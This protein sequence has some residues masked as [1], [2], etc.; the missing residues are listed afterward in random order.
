MPYRN[1]EPVNFLL[2]DD[3]EEN[4]ISLEAL[5]RH[6][7]VN[8]LKA[9]SGPEALELLLKHDIGLA[10]LDVQMPE[11]DGFELAELMRG[12][13]RTSK[14]PIIFLTAGSV[15]R[16][17]RFRGYE[18]G[19]VDFIQKPI[20]PDILRSKAQVFYNLRRQQRMIELQ[21][22]ALEQRSEA[23]READIQKDQFIAMLA[24]ELR[25]PLAPIK[26]G[27]EILGRNPDPEKAANILDMMDRQVNHLIRLI[28]DL[29]DVSRITHNKIDLRRSVIT[30]QSAIHSAVET[31]TP[32]IEAAG[33]RFNLVV[34]DEDIWIDADP[35][36]IAQILGNLINNAVKYTP[37]GGRIFLSL[38]LE[39][40][41]AVVSVTD[42][43]LGID[44]D[45]LPK[46]FELFAQVSPSSATSQ[47]G[48]GIG[49]ALVKRLVEM[50][51]GTISVESPGL[52]HGSTFI[53]R[54]PVTAAPAKVAER[55]KSDEK[56]EHPPLKILTVDDNIPSA[57]TIGWMLEM[58]GHKQMTAHTGK[59][60][61]EIARSAAPD[62]VLLD[63]GLPDISGYDVCRELRKDPRF[64][65]TTFIAQ[66][67]WGQEKD[68]QKALEAGF[69]YHLVKPVNLNQLKELLHDI[70]K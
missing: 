52:G 38:R 41:H 25:N 17:R 29:L 43:G 20:E 33:H 44:E 31:A 34:P 6:D 9:H 49:L 56:R 4:L 54:L 36:R 64:E 65:H 10:L 22:V 62:V 26:N 35:T 23:L 24:H 32:Q 16:N 59:D 13:E 69:N 51:G 37:A 63:I 70:G 68:K 39:N 40:G 19:A 27:L 67:G 47:G 57:Q 58:I 11:M 66:T 21:M 42:N 30:A 55:A 8:I 14:V 3:L 53:V 2:V 18:T 46:V 7:D 12:S 1:I 28:D 50:H 5:L 48:L 45:M 60:A 15:D 61:L